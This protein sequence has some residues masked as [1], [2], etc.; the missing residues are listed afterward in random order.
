MYLTVS[1]ELFWMQLTLDEG[2]ALS[3]Q[4]QIYDH[5]RQQ[6]FKK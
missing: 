2:V 4:H 5:L 1:V 3:E 6:G